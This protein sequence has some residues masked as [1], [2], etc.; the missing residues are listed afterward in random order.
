QSTR[1]GGGVKEANQD[2][3]GDEVLTSG[4][5]KTGPA[6]PLHRLLRAG[7]RKTVDLKELE[8]IHIHKTSKLLE[9]S[10]VCGTI[11]GGGSVV[12]VERLRSYARCIGLLFQVVDDILDVTKS[13]EELGKTAGKDLSSEKATYPKLMGI[14][15]ARKFA[16][17]LVEKAIHKLSYFD[18]ARAAPLYHLAYYIANRQN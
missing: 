1:R 16:D 17:E 18:A 8:Y 13:S 4:R 12:D 11:V 7:R 2:S 5:R 10:V 6:N 15:K 3:R 9:A 14:E